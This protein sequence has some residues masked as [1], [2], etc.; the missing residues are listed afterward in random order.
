MEHVLGRQE[1]GGDWMSG[2]DNPEQY[3]H[4]FVVNKL[5]LGFCIDHACDMECRG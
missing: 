5:D 3:F 2:H 1:M 4:Q